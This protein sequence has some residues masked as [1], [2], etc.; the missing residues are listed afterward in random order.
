MMSLIEVV[1]KNKL[2]FRLRFLPIQI[3]TPLLYTYL[4]N[5]NCSNNDTIT[6]R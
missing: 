6:P 3:M 1:C 5:R 4:I 2:R